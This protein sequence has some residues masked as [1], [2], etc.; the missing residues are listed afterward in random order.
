MAELEA[1][2]AQLDPAKAGIDTINGEASDDEKAAAKKTVTE[3]VFADDDSFSWIDEAQFIFTAGGEYYQAEEATGED[4]IKFIQFRKLN[5]DSEDTTAEVTSDDLNNLKNN[6]ANLPAYNRTYKQTGFTAVEND[7]TSYDV[8]AELSWNRRTLTLYVLVG[9]S[10]VRLDQAQN[11][12]SF[13]TRGTGWNARTVRHTVSLVTLG[14]SATYT[15]TEEI[16]A[17]TSVSA[18]DAW[19]EA[20]AQL[21][22]A[23]SDRDAAKEDKDAAEAQAQN[24]TDKIAARDE[25]QAT[26]DEAEKALEEA[27]AYDPTADEE[28]L[29]EAKQELKDI[30]KDLNGNL[31]E[32][33]IVALIHGSDDEFEDALANFDP[34]EYLSESDAANYK[35]YSASNG[36]F[37]KAL[38]LALYAKAFGAVTQEARDQAQP[39][40]D[41][42]TAVK[43]NGGLS[44]E[45]A[46]AVYDLLTSDTLSA[47]TKMAL[48]EALSDYL[49]N[50]YESAT[51]TL[52]NV[53]NEG[54]TST[55]EAISDTANT[56]IGTIRNEGSS[57]VSRI[58]QSATSAFSRTL[59]RF[60]G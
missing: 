12:W 18:T 34:T 53:I 51:D 13:T 43:E 14:K 9:S 56:A 49:G 60:F 15:P 35:K 1:I 20:N 28:A 32:Q 31:I 54:R 59:G 11:G 52:Q 3:K 10:V 30:D 24:I 22:G 50:T 38:A 5:K 46:T 36:I 25:A 57:G 47:N 45:T 16:L 17:T 48:V 33:L 4:E 55:I 21:P 39:I 44:L 42:I 27:T 37:Q 40:I 2:L 29:A 8:V 7:S 6:Y 23:K 41:V 58:F 19:D 26:L